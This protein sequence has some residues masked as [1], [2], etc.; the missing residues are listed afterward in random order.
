MTCSEAKKL[1]RWDAIRLVEEIATRA[2]I[3]GIGNAELL[4]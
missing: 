2:H 1:P 3:E 4:Q